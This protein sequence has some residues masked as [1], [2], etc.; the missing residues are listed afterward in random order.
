MDQTEN[1]RAYGGWIMATQEVLD[2]LCPGPT[3]LEPLPPMGVRSLARAWSY[4]LRSK[5]ALWI[6]PWLSRADYEDW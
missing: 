3:D 6:A 5:L 1:V 2:D 4:D